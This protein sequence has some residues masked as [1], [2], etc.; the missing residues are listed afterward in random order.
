MLAHRH[1]SFSR[2]VTWI[3]LGLASAGWA[4]TRSKEG[5]KQ[6]RAAAAPTDLRGA[7]TSA[8]DPPHAPAP[9]PTA[10]V[11]STLEASIKTSV[12]AWAS[13][14]NSGDFA[15][16]ERLYAARF[17]GVKRV[18]SFERRFDR[19]GWLRDRQAMFKK[20]VSVQVTELRVLSAEG[21]VVVEFQQTW[22]SGAYRDVGRKRLQLVDEG[23]LKI[24]TESLLDSAIATPKSPSENRPEEFSWVTSLATTSGLILE[25]GVDL[26]A[27][28]GSP[29][30]I[31][32]ERI[33]RPLLTKALAPRYQALVGQAFNVYSASGQSCAARVSGFK[34]LVEAVP[35]FGMVQSWNGTVDG[36]RD[37]GPKAG[38][39]QRALS[40]WRLS[41][42]GGRF[43]VAELDTVCPE[44]LWARSAA[45]PAPSLWRSRALSDD[46]L[47]AARKAARSSAEYREL[48]RQFVAAFAKSVPW[49]ETGRASERSVAFEDKAGRVYYSLLMRSGEDDGCGSAFDVDRWFLLQKQ[50][51]GLALVSAP[52]Q[53]HVESAMPRVLAPVFAEHALDLDGDGQLELFGGRD[54]FAHGRRGFAAISNLSGAF[55]DCGC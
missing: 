53:D 21:P 22:S 15:A 14:Q 42:A 49:D 1:P 52:N 46:E 50:A 31:S 20:P 30:Y 6:T 51:S 3:L 48:Q 35:H 5:E 34:V 39:A 43:L 7:R 13:S 45:L 11:D 41:E 40:L 9:A 26:N 37:G 28:Q 17:T 32:D 8:P 19:A 44:G 27:V 10:T 12:E 18:G 54:L 29:M 25:R 47:A 33:E 55:F 16:Y 24:T 23:G 38:P 2:L 36:V 4:C